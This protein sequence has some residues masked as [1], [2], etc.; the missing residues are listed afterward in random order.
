MPTMSLYAMVQSVYIGR[1]MS[2][3]YSTVMYSIITFN[4]LTASP[5][6]HILYCPIQINMPTAKVILQT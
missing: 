4:L 1:S 5:L 6:C 3:C 2:V